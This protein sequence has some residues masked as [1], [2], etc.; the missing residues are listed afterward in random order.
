M[1]FFFTII[2]RGH[3][4]RKRSVVLNK[5]SVGTVRLDAVP[6]AGVKRALI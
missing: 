2:N 4:K 1:D 3:S 5:F 6:V